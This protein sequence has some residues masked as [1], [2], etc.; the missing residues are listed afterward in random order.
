MH[1]YTELSDPILHASTKGKTKYLNDSCILTYICIQWTSSQQPL[2]EQF[3]LY[4]IAYKECA[5]LC[6]RIY[7]KA[8]L[9]V[10]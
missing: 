10:C 6:N 5:D 2:T 3:S 1:I 7:R 4:Y 8:Q 9:D